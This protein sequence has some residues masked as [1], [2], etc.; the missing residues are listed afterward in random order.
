[1]VMF[2]CSAV[3]CDEEAGVFIAWM[4]FLAKRRGN[5]STASHG[6]AVLLP[7][8]PQRPANVPLSPV[9]ADDGEVGLA[10]IPAPMS[11]FVAQFLLVFVTITFIG[12]AL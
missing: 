5:K 2:V 12:A 11:P 1:M 9:D 10:A 4:Y 3:S 6:G 8:T 7:S